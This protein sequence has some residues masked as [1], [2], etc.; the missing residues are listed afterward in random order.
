VHVHQH[1]TAWHIDRQ[2]GRDKRQRG[3]KIATDFSFQVGADSAI[4]FIQD[5]ADTLKGK[6]TLSK[7]AGTYSIT[8]PAVSGYTTTYD[9]CT[10]VVLAAAGTQTC[11]I[12]NDDQAGTLIVKKVVIND[13]GGTKI[14]TDFTFQV[15]GGSATGFLQDG[16]D[17]LKGKNTLS[18]SAGT[19]SVTEPAVTG[20]T[21]TYDSC[22]NVAVG[23]G[24]TKTCTI[25]NDDQAGTLIVKKIVI[26][27]NGGTKIA[28]NFSFQ[29]NGGSAT[30]FVQDGADT[31]K[32]KNTLSV[33]AGTYS[34]TEPAVTGYTTTYDSCSNVAVG[35]GDTKTCTI[36]ND[37]QR[38][39]SS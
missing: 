16:A 17:T 18:V 22:S 14:A 39:R 4:G 32:G 6:N 20:Y 8:E 23:N 28:T 25:T 26:N 31:L 38:A 10:N 9:N 34:V 2:E 27:D 7:D 30:G 21:T 11:T 29:V 24:D 15:N 37:D 1:T 35:N 13:N 5:G 33:S 3:H 12:T 36:T 19:Y